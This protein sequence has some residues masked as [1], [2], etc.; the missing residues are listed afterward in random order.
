MVAQLRAELGLPEPIHLPPDLSVPL[1]VSDEQLSRWREADVAGSADAAYALGVRYLQQPDLEMAG[2]YFARAAARGSAEAMYGRYLLTVAQGAPPDEG[3]RLLDEAA[4]AGSPLAA[5][6]VY[7][8]LQAD[9]SADAD[10]AAATVRE[11]AAAADAAGSA[12]A[13]FVLAWLGPTAQD[14]EAALQRA[15]ERGSLNAA[16]AV[17]TAAEAAGDDDRAIEAYLLS[18]RRG[19]PRAGLALGRLLARTGP[20][21]RGSAGLAADPPDRRPSPVTATSSRRRR[22]SWC[23]RCG[24]CCAATASLLPSACSPRP[25]PRARP[26]ALGRRRSAGGC[27]A[28]GRSVPTRRGRDVPAGR[29]RA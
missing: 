14:R 17:A 16:V 5:L 6:G 3:R 27:G 21:G 10:E 29:R 25:A 19:Y 1:V 4:A 26:V 24:L 23:R 2:E 9:G 11:L 8:S 28:A 7:A 22:L 12:D 15:F 13:A 18:A 20:P